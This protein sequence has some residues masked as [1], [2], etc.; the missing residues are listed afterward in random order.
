MESF[1]HKKLNEVE[2]KEQSHDEILNK[3]TASENVDAAVDTNSTWEHIRE[4]IRVSAKD[5][6]DYCEL[7]CISHGLIK[8]A[9]NY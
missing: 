7:R 6:L 9:Q 2:G 8:D 1:N 5:S 4:N 3:S